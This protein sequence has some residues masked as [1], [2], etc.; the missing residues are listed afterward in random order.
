MPQISLISDVHLELD[1]APALKGGD[2]LLLAGD[3]LTAAHIENRGAARRP[4]EA[5]CK[6]E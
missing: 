6:K 5:F 3:I 2:I 1:E 4:F